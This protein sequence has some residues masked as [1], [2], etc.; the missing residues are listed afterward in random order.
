MNVI[1]TMASL[2]KPGRDSSDLVSVGYEP[3]VGLKGFT[4]DHEVSE[5]C[6]VLSQMLVYTEGRGG[7]RG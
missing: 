2:P 1:G 7:Q 6:P 4:L 3:G 5:K